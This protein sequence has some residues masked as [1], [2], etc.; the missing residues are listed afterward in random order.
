MLQLIDDRSGQLHIKMVMHAKPEDAFPGWS[1]K[2]R[3]GRWT[4]SCNNE[5][6]TDQKRS[7]LLK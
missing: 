4:G 1:T 6:M 7:T 3:S 2:K 5:I